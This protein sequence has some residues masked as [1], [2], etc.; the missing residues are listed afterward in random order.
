[1]IVGILFLEETHEDK[2][3]RRDFGL[4]IGDWI[5]NLFCS[6][7]IDEKGGIVEESFHLLSETMDGQASD[8]SSTGTSPT[9]T[10][11]VSAG[12]L[13]PPIRPLNAA[14]KHKMGMSNMFS[15]Q[16][17]LVIVSYGILA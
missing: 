8:Y 12:D 14:V 15:K 3:D 16:V 5:L 11:V 6:E 10:P 4:E 2:K 1:M 7:T 13:V 17:L 9:L